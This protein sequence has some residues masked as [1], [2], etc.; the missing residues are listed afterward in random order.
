M[1]TSR[2]LLGILVGILAIGFLLLAVVSLPPKASGLY[3]QKID[4][5]WLLSQAVHFSG[6]E[7]SHD[8]WL[9]INFWASWCPPCREEM[10]QLDQL[11]EAR[12]WPAPLTLLTL[13]QDQSS[14]VLQAYWRKYQFTMDGRID[15][16]QV[17]STAW[18]IETYPTT[19]LI[20][21]DNTVRWIGYYAEDWT[22]PEVMNL[23]AQEMQP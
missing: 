9:I 18:G 19:L 7:A 17:I 5:T 12:Q 10:P 13:S 20:A 21:P 23:I 15:P 14:E 3:G 22:D 11:I 8:Q 4:R 16:E 6:I 1:P 2:K